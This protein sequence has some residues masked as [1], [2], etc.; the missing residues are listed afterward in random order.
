MLKPGGNI[1]LSCPN[2]PYYY[3]QGTPGNPFHKKQYTY[4]DFKQL[5]EKYLGQ[6]VRYY[7]AYAL[8]GFGQ[9]AD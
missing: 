7:L 9:S 3:K 2:D 1:I 4:F 8:N 5:A 6:R